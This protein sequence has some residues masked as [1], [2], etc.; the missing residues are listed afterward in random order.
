MT[1]QPYLFDEERE[2]A[3]AVECLRATYSEPDYDMENPNDSDELTDEALTASADAL[4]KPFA[5]AFR[6]CYSRG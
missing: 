3:E 6:K 4:I 5:T 2:V 1:G